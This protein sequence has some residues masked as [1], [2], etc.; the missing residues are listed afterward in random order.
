MKKEIKRLLEAAADHATFTLGC[1]GGGGGT[2]QRVEVIQ[3]CRVAPLEVAA[4][5]EVRPEPEPAAGGA[6]S[7]VPVET[8]SR[9]GLEPHRHHAVFQFV[10]ETGGVRVTMPRQVPGFEGMSRL[11]RDGTGTCRTQPAFKPR[12]IPLVP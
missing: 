1:G 2:I 5:Y 4:E 6:K 3:T 12:L 7:T 10:R 8:G 11:D 9:L